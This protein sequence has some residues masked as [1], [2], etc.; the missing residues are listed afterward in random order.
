MLGLD[1]QTEIARSPCGCL[2]NRWQ[3]RCARHNRFAKGDVCSGPSL[4]NA[5]CI[6]QRRPQSVGVC[7]LGRIGETHNTRGNQGPNTS[8]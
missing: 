2:A 8:G 7:L 3:A 5:G 4:D 1:H 6:N